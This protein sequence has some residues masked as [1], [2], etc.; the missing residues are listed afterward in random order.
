MIPIDL[1]S[2]VSVV[3]GGNKGIGRGI[4]ERLAQAG[5]SVVVVSRHLPEC[6]A[7]AREMQRQYGIESMALQAD[8]SKVEDIEAMIDQAIRRLSRIDVLVNNAG[9]ALRVPALEI[10][11]E[12]WEA[13]LNTNLRGS[14]FCAKEAARRMKDQGG[15]SIINVGSVHSM[16]AMKLYAHYGAS[17][18]GLSQLTRVLALEWGE[19]QIRVN[20]VA[21]GSVPTDINRDVL[22]IPE[23]RQRNINKTV[24]KRLGTPQDIAGIVAFLASDHASYITGQTIYVDGGW[25]LS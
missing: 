2:K 13:V 21:P 14:F 1:S 24:L 10:T 23:N 12:I 15:G 9:I 16:T 6:Q 11:R 22:A 5:A 3:T 4:V 25:T 8:I 7:V 19:Y 18:A 17:K 20:C